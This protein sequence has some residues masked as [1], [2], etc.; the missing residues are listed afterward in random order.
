MSSP[1][2]L[3]K[4]YLSGISQVQH[5]EVQLRTDVG[6]FVTI[7]AYRYIVYRVFHP[8]P[9]SPVHALIAPLKT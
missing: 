8:I 9:S 5:S 2:S 6:D 3:L 4:M 1:L 7:A